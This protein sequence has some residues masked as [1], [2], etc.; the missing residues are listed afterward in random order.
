M[1]NGRI[2]RRPITPVTPS[3][4][5]SQRLRLGM[6]LSVIKSESRKLKP[7]QRSERVFEIATRRR[8]RFL[9]RLAPFQQLF[10]SA[11]FA[12]EVNSTGSPGIEHEKTL[13]VAFQMRRDGRCEVYQRKALPVSLRKAVS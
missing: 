2:N 1:V 3:A 10:I 4:P 12:V 13:A 7:F 9:D 8:H 5:H 11:E 6:K